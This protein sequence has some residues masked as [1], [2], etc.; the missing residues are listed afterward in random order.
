LVAN[1]SVWLL[2]AVRKASCVGKPD[3][4]SVVKLPDDG[5]ARLGCID[6]LIADGVIEWKDGAEGFARPY[7]GAAP[8]LN[9]SK[10]GNDVGTTGGAV[11]PT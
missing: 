6:M 8:K 7:A 5:V 11:R 10:K 2:V 9:V 1:G 4:G 3:D